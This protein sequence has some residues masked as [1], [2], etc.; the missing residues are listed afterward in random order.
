MTS[1]LRTPACVLLLCVI[2]GGA[3]MAQQA[4][5]PGPRRLPGAIS[6]DEATLLA[7][8]YAFLTQGN[9]LR[10]REKVDEARARF[11]RSVNVLTLAV[12]VAIAQG[13]ATLGLQEYETHL[14]GR[15]MEEPG[16]LHRIAVA[17]LREFAVQ[18]KDGFAKDAAQWALVDD[19]DAEAYKEVFKSALASDTGAVRRLAERGDPG[20]VKALLP[21]LMKPRTP[22]AMAIIKSLGES[23]S[24][25]AIEALTLKLS[26]PEPGIRAAAVDALAKVG[27]A[28]VIGRIKPLLTD[29]NDRTGAVRASAA[30]ALLALND[31][32]GIQILRELAESP[33]A[34]GRVRAAELMASRPDAAWLSLV[35]GLVELPDDPNQ[36]NSEIRLQAAKLLAEHDQQTAAAALER[37]ST[38]NNPAIR[39]E[40]LRLMASDLNAP[41][42]AL[43]RLLRHPEW[44]ISVH[45]AASISRLTR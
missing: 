38:H 12:E 32:S 36:D 24:S 45:A 7:S 28:A 15:T 18:T 21:I 37:H 43:R 22:N 8:G 20:A 3:F 14:T 19:G 6:V 25:L 42:P 35:R 33:Y 30:G 40:A 26:D 39:Q 10:A 13:G 41:L 9:N 23:G 29:P 31:F 11:P 34:T 27:G 17:F 1:M 16:L 44:L 5:Q 4:Q 2:F